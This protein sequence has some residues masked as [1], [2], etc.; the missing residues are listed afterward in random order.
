MTSTWLGIDLGTSSVKAVLIDETQ[1]IIATAGALLSV[2]RPHPGWSEQH[3]DYWWQAT[4]RALD[5]L[6]ADHGPAMAALRGIGLSGQMHGATLLDAADK[7]LR[8]AILWNDGRASRECELLE[9]RAPF[10][11][12]G[13]NIVMPG[14]TAP[15]LEWVRRHEPETF[16]K[17]ETVLLPKDYLRLLL[18]GEKVSEMSDSAG[19]LWMDV[20]Q[21]RWAPELLAATS[22]TQSHMPRLAEGSEPTAT[23]RPDL[24]RRWGIDG[25]PVIAG[26]G[27]DNAA[28]ACGVGAVRPGTGFL[29]IGTS[30]VLFAATEAFEPNTDSAV[31]AFCHAVPGTWCQMGVILAAADSLDWLGGITGTDTREL[32]RM[33]G[34]EEVL[35]ERPLF[36]PYLSGERTPHNDA[37]LRG[38]FVGL[39]RRHGPADLA[40]AVLEG[41]AYAFTDCVDALA[42]AGTRLQRVLA[43]GGGAGSDTW[44]QII[45]DATGLVLDRAEGV[46]EAAATGAARLAIC[47]SEGAD[48]AEVCRPAPVSATFEPDGE[49]AAEHERRL[50]RFR[51]C[52]PV[53]KSSAG[54]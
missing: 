49:A 54:A 35:P 4:E 37:R 33:V 9:E 17:I 16:A 51:A 32:V 26:G 19:T 13:G 40:R 12:V 34:A 10:R 24:A 14:F 39:G 47:A 7:P 52:Y 5:M 20:A 11:Q 38:A 23:L 46:R 6:A 41:V 21:R 3:P 1:R 28:A 50:T 29:S 43:I 25:A 22:L 2:Q 42:G 30:G 18:T 44:L 15:K 8:P 48:P 27:G 36:L 53:L 31:H 45:A